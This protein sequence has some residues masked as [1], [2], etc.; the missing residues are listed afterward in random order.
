MHKLLFG[1][2]LSGLLISFAACSEDE[3]KLTN[4]YQYFPGNSDKTEEPNDEELI[5]Y[6]TPDRTKIAAFPG[7]FGA[8]RY[9]TGGAGGKVYTVTSLADNGAVGTLRWALNQSETRT[10]VFAVSGIIDL[11]QNLTIQKGNV[12][13]AGQTAPGD[14]ICLK[15][16]PVILEADNVIIRFMRFRLGDEQ[17]NNAET[18]DADA[19]F[20]RNQKNIIIDHCSMSWCTDECA[21]FYGNTNFT[22]QWCLI[23]ESLAN[24]IHP[25]GAHG[26]GGIWGGSPATFHHNLLAHHVSRTPRLCGSRYS[27]SPDNEKVDVRNNVFYNWGAGNGG[28][29]GEGGNYNF[30]NNY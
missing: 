10:I 22:M 26:Y 13:I 17:I 16:Y 5:D 3:A 11:Q 24:S 27:N 18:K 19:I 7:A 12:T 15:R 6:P 8:G 21:S 4:S 2:F 9:T 1:A 20:G 14:G 25:K 29:A 30:V 23:A 28:Y